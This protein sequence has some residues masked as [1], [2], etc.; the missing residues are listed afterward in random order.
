[1]CAPLFSLQIAATAGQPKFIKNLKVADFMPFGCST[2]FYV[3]TSTPLAWI[4]I[5]A[6]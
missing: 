5:L 6:G 2:I 1:M 3:A 4:N